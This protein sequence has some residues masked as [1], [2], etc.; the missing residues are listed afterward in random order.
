[1]IEIVAA[2]RTSGSASLIRTLLCQAT[3]EKK[4]TALL[5]GGDSL[6]VTSLDP[7]VLSRLLWVRCRSAEETIKA[8]DLLLRDGNVPLVLLDLA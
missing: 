5:D 2:T 6:D 1:L 4:I 8:A 3:E 7:A